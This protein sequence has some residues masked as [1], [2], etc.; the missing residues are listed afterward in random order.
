MHDLYV[1]LLAGLEPRR[2]RHSLS[3]GLKVAERAHVAPPRLRA[4]LVTSAVLHDIGYAHPDT[5]FH[6]ID[7]ATVLL[8][9]GFS[10]LICH[11]V[12]T[13]TAAELEA[14]ERGLPATLFDRFPDPDGRSVPW[15]ALLMW[16][17]L[18]TGPDGQDMTVTERLDEILVRYTDPADPVRRYV[19]R[20]REQLIHQAQPPN[21]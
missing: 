14:A 3:V 10:P 7:G 21:V 5:G 2:R 19:L 17:D 9:L 12:A 1:D 13:H 15:R 8:E 4:E 16:A 6:P 18:T 11:L 20:S